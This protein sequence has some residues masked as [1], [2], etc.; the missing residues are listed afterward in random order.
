MSNERHKAFERFWN[1]FADMRHT[2]HN[3][4]IFVRGDG[5]ELVDRDGN[6]YL[7]ATASLWYCNVG[8]GRQEIASAIGTQ[9]AKLASCSCF[10]VY[11]SDVTLELADRVS[12]LSP[13]D[14]AAVFLTSGGSDSV[15]TAAKLARRY[16]AELGEPDRTFVL[17]RESAYH[18]TH[19]FGTSIAGLAANREHFGPLVEDVGTVPAMSSSALASAMEEIGCERVAAFIAEPV[20]GAGGVYPPPPGY[21]TEVE[22]ICTEREVLL[23]AD[24]VVTGFGRTGCMFAAERYEFEPDMVILAKGIT[25]GYL[26][27]GAVVCAERVAA[28]FWDGAPEEPLRHGYTYSGHATACAAAQANLDLIEAEGLVDRVAALEPRFE[29]HLRA[30]L[31]HPAVA[32][33]RS[34]GLMGG[35]QLDSEWLAEAGITSA[36]VVS[37]CR[38]RGVL[39]RVL[40]GEALQITPPFVIEDEQLA[41]IF[42]VLNEV[43]GDD[44]IVGLTYNMRK[45][46]PL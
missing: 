36:G 37:A 45:A 41:R 11:A 4:V 31:R 13:L 27:L 16:W 35:V 24:E 29:E 43:F 8:H 32:E 28:P 14:D 30:L 44:R 34:V 46:G 33:V 10:D 3:R 22:A 7:D 23:I 38:E 39:T 6:T 9:A 26:P 12:E 21:L 5:C 20:I 17:S 19:A 15:D 40:A 42:E 2:K 1:P 25:S 18:G